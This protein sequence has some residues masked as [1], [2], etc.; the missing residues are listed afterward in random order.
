MPQSDVALCSN[1]PARRLP[2]GP[3]FEDYWREVGTIEA[4]WS[5]HMDLVSD[6]PPYNPGD[7]A[8]PL[9]TEAGNR[10]ATHI[11]AGAE[12]TD[13]LLSPGCRV[14]GAVRRSVLSSGVVVEAPV[15]ASR[16]DIDHT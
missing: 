14:A 4:Y 15:S 16:R 8:W 1:T 9:T 10:S 6:E 7:R 12:I 3:R 13:A 11:L 2:T 5:A